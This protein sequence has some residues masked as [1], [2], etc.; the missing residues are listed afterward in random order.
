MEIQH[1]V[2]RQLVTDRDDTVRQCQSLDEVKWLAITEILP[3]SQ[4]QQ[5]A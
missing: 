5:R 1:N 3:I 4:S 2:A